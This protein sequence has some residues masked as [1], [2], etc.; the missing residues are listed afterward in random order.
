MIEYEIRIEKKRDRERSRHRN[1]VGEK[2]TKK[3][4][5][6]QSRISEQ[7]YGEILV[8]RKNGQKTGESYREIEKGYILKR[9]GGENVQKIHSKVISQCF[10][11]VRW[12]KGRRG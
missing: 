10:F 5:E 12:G 3:G 9:G 8:D 7:K 11:R 6:S 4:S 2:C 1:I